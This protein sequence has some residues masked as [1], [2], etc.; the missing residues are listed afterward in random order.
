[1]SYEV[2]TLTEP[3]AN[4]VKAVYET[5]TIQPG[6]VALVTGPG[7]VGM[8]AALLIEVRALS[9]EGMGCMSQR[10]SETK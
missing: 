6:D 8:L 9:G 7:P 5:S 10:G 3:L 1:V 4:S 2:G